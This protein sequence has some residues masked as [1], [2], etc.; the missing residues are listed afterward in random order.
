MKNRGILS[1]MPIELKGKEFFIYANLV[2]REDN[3]KWKNF[4]INTNMV[5][6]K[7]QP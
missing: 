1:L 4:I 2:D 6:K 3:Q 5:E 7:R